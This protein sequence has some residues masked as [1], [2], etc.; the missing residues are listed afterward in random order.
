MRAWVLLCGCALLLGS[1]PA[2]SAVSEAEVEALRE[3]VRLLSERLDQLER[4]AR[5]R[6]G[7]EALVAAAMPSAPGDAELERRIEAAVD[8][9]VEERMAAVA[10]AERI[11]W[12]GDLRYR[13]ENTEQEGKADRD[14][15]RIRARAGLQARVSDTVRAGFGLAS[16]SGD[17]VSTNQTLGD[18]A[19]HKP[20]TLDLA[21]FDWTPAMGAVISGGKFRNLLQAVGGSP[22]LW[23]SDWRP[24]G[25]ALAY[26]RPSWFAT[27]VGTWLESDSGSANQEFSYALQAGFRVPLGARAEIM[28]GFGYTDIDAAGKGAFFEG[29]GF[30]GNSFDPASGVYLHDYRLIEGFTEVALE[31]FGR[32]MTLFADYVGNLEVDDHDTGYSF[33][34]EIGEAKA[35]GTWSFGYT[36][37]KLEADAALG[38]LADSDFAGGGTDNQ[39]SL[40][41]GAYAFHDSWFVDL[42]YFI[43]ETG[44]HSG[45]PSDYDRLQVDMNFKYR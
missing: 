39:G 6:V 10:W 2:R 1:A 20:V 13:F 30:F 29:G 25:F 35:R 8:A 33:G 41:H 21:Y 3:Q 42:R 28:A 44:L 24:E 14:R 17:P 43:N 11:N 32:P 4:E 15:S 22:L 38:L 16:G 27:G 31:A 23:D 5:E 7:D 9:Q 26:I 12:Y 19:S 45:D 18:G 40:L 37:R 34:F 36:Y